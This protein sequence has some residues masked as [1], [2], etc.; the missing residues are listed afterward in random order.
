MHLGEGIAHHPEWTELLLFDPELPFTSVESNAG[1]CP[2]ESAGRVA[3]VDLNQGEGLGFSRMMLLVDDFGE[4][5]GQDSLY[6]L[7]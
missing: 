3:G 1:P 4:S 5:H 6:S 7:V 2:S